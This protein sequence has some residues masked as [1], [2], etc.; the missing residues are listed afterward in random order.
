MKLFENEQQ[1]INSKYLFRI[2]QDITEY[3]KGYTIIFSDGSYYCCSDSPYERNGGYWFDKGNLASFDNDVE[4]GIIKDISWY[5]LSESIRN[6]IINDI[7]YDFE[8]NENIGFCNVNVFETKED[9]IEENL[10]T[11][12]SAGQ[13][14]FT[15]GTCFFMKTENG[16]QGPYKTYNEAY[17]VSLPDHYAL[18]GPEFH[19]PLD[20]FRKV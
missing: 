4:N 19:S 11:Y 17:R 18:A 8:S 12:N 9:A 5:D 6:D 13:G 15:H 1:F 14:I 3:E 10:G 16:L 2:F 20:L 7:N